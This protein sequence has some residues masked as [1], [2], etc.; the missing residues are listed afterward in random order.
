MR[1]T[2]Y[3]AQNDRMVTLSKE[4]MQ[5]T[6][7]FTMLPVEWDFSK[8]ILLHKL[9]DFG[10]FMSS[11][12]GI[13]NQK[14]QKIQEIASTGSDMGSL[15]GLCSNLLWRR[16]KC[17]RPLSAMVLNSVFFKGFGKTKKKNGRFA[18]EKKPKKNVGRF[19]TKKKP[20]KIKQNP[21]IFRA[22]REKTQKKS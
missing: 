20:K 1:R 9:V 4:E 18:A 10:S 13:A 6:I 17:V 16:F 5:I 15:H 7:I 22:S 21:Q 11:F 3:D 2:I 14:A 19:A 8:K 12:S